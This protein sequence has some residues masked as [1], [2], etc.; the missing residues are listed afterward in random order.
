M[1]LQ[2]PVWLKMLR[3]VNEFGYHVRRDPENWPLAVITLGTILYGGFLTLSKYYEV[4]PKFPPHS[5][6][7][8]ID[9]IKARYG[10]AIQPEEPVDH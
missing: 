10:L 5:S 3:N 9:P 8:Q 4:V 2:N 7:P 6:E 1:P